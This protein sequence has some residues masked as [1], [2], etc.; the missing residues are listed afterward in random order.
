MG[1]IM[2]VTECRKHSACGGTVLNTFLSSLN[3]IQP[4]AI[5]DSS[6]PHQWYRQNTSVSTGCYRTLCL[7]LFCAGVYLSWSAV[8][9]WCP[10]GN[11]PF[12]MICLVAYFIFQVG[13]VMNAFEVVVSCYHLLTSTPSHVLAA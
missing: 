6:R 9:P 1:Y 4:S 11:T 10:F 12:G 3:I 13:K 8:A 5:N 7:N 2:C